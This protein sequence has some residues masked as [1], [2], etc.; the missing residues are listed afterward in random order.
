MTFS[1]PAPWQSFR[2]LLSLDLAEVEA[3]VDAAPEL[4]P[5]LDPRAL[6]TPLE[7]FHRLM[8]SSHV[9][10]T[11]VDLGAGVGESV[12]FYTW[13]FPERQAL[14][15][16]KSVARVAAGNAAKE[17]L[18]LK[19][20]ILEEADLG[21]ADI[22][23]AETYFLY[24]PTG[25]VLD[26]VLAELRRKRRFRCLIAIESHGDL[27]P[28]L[29]KENWLE[30]LESVPLSVPRLDSH[31]RIYGRREVPEVTGPHQ[32]SFLQR[33]LIVREESGEEWLGE[34]RGLEWLRGDEYQLLLPPRSIRWSQVKSILGF[35]DL[36]ELWRFLCELRR[37][38]RELCVS[39]ER[40]AMRGKLRK[41]LI[42]PRM[43]LELSS[44]E[45]VEWSHIMTLTL[46]GSLC[47][48][49]SRSF[50]FLPP[51]PTTMS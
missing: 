41:I 37:R 11:W 28:R 35:S 20:A 47:Y 25:P 13:L 22:P 8:T 19:R 46:D 48:D 31:A 14:G 9:Q 50:Y 44:G 23:D 33:M 12:L 18:Q 34:S 17:R 29:E 42:S 40:G 43:A 38:D 24:F 32:L 4:Y 21:I 1:S 27:I 39:S 3:R 45:R 36:P 7:D 6:F 5:G 15:L 30:L 51:A 49:S 2:D 26:R 10:G 16:E